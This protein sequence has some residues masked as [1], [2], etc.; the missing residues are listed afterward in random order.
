[1][2]DAEEAYKNALKYVD[3]ASKL[4]SDKKKLFQKEVSEALAIFKKA[5]SNFR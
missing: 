2:A 5:P 3:K 4:S 1:M